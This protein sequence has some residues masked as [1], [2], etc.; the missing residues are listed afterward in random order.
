MSLRI[1]SKLNPKK[2]YLQV[3][4]NS[5]LADAQRIISELPISDRI[6]VEVGTPLIKRY[7]EEGIGQIRQW[8]EQR[9]Y[10][11]DAG[12]VEAPANFQLNLTSII[13]AIIKKDYSALTRL[14]PH[15]AGLRQGIGVNSRNF[16]VGVKNR[17]T[18]IKMKKRD[19][20]PY[21]YVV[22][23][24][25]TMDR[26]GTE[27]EIAARAGA[28]AAVALGSAPVETLNAFMDSCEASGLDAMIDMMNVEYPLSVLR[29]LKK[30]PPVVILHRGVDEEQ[31]NKQKQIPLHE[32]RRVKGNYNIMISIAG[33]DT[34]RE[35][36]R[37]IFNDADIVVIWK[38]VY[39]STGETI[40]LVEEFL[41]EI[42]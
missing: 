3:A 26:G 17:A 40:G 39:Q 8:F 34:I 14:N 5:T 35:V 16:G 9:L 13:S 22:A 41:K 4:L 25:K 28:S 36:Q 1:Q 19:D 32:I 21:P 29:A 27:V 10:G 30:V 6:I 24:L 31:F 12:D 38:S 33:G 23:D 37:S 11:F 42:K 18:Q 20:K 7:G 15:T 2:K